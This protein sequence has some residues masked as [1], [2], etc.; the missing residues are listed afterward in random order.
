M[1]P[2]RIAALGGSL[3]AGSVSTAALRTCAARARRAGAEVTLLCGP[4]LALPPY[5]PEAGVRSA[6]ELRLLAALRAADGVLLAS[7]TYHGGM[8]GL[9]KNAL[10]HTEALAKDTPGYLDG[11]AVGCLTVAWNEVA[12]ASALA[13]LRASA[14]ALRGWAVPMGVVVSAATEF[15]AADTCADPRAAR[16]LDIL[17]DQVLDFA[18]MRRSCEAAAVPVGSGVGAAL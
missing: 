8:S 2:I 3:R 18:R 12:G 5:D 15:T 7:P 4:E 9:L 10:D 14:Q 16:R 13:S 6:A 1:R 11:R 17:T